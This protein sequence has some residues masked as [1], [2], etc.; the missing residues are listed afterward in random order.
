[1]PQSKE[2]VAQALKAAHAAGDTSAATKLARA[3]RDMESQAEM[4][5]EFLEDPSANLVDTPYPAP[6]PK[7]RSKEVSDSTMW[8]AGGYS[9]E[10]QFEAYSKELEAKYGSAEGRIKMTEGGQIVIK[11]AD[12]KWSVAGANLGR[13]DA[14]KAVPLVTEGVGDVVGSL[15]GGAVGALGGPAAPFT[16][17]AGAIAGGALGASGGRYVGGRLVGESKEDAWRESKEAAAWS[18]AGGTAF[19]GFRLLKGLFR[20]F[21]PALK[22]SD[23]QLLRDIRPEYKD[24][25]DQMGAN[26]RMDQLRDWDLKGQGNPAHVALTDKINTALNNPQI[27]RDEARRIAGDYD[28]LNSYLNPDPLTGK[29]GFDYAATAGM[30]MQGAL[31]A[32][33]DNL[34]GKAEGEVKTSLK[35]LEKASQGL[36]GNEDS[37][38]IGETASMRAS[39]LA[40]AKKAE[41]DNLWGT[42]RQAIGQRDPM[43]P[44]SNNMIEVPDN[45]KSLAGDLAIAEQGAITPAAKKG[46]KMIL[47]SVSTGGGTVDLAALDDA[48]YSQGAKVRRLATQNAEGANVARE[49]MLLDRLKQWRDD[50]GMKLPEEANAAY[51]QANR[52]YGEYADEYEK[53]TIGKLLSYNKDGAIVLDDPIKLINVFNSGDKSAIRELGQLAKKDPNLT[54]EMRKLAYG[55]YRSQVMSDGLVDLNKHKQFMSNLSQGGYKEVLEGLFDAKD[56]AKLTKVG[57]MAETVLTNQRALKAAE[58]QWDNTMGGWAGKLMDSDPS[59]FVNAVFKT[60][61]A[62]N[63]ISPASLGHAMSILK[64]T[65]KATGL[66]MVEP[67]RKAVRQRLIDQATAQSPDGALDPRVLKKALANNHDRL[68]AALGGSEYIKKLENVIGH[69]ERMGSQRMLPAPYSPAG[70]GVI[71]DIRQ[72]SMGALS[73]E[74]LVANLAGGYRRRKGQQDLYEALVNPAA[75][76]RMATYYD[77]LAVKMTIA[78]LTG[79]VAED[80]IEY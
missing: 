45:I 75:L 25:A 71:G 21:G 39:E 17:P 13:E 46:F 35:K 40:Q 54:N 36:P 6:N 65:E 61:G 18:A 80:Q 68:V 1:M 78:N 11:N 8:K 33:Y 9:P 27:Q 31:K 57:G 7:Y 16:A 5:P 62:Q 15:G 74:N 59:L 26:P 42:Y 44:I 63:A 2:Q 3:L 38:P 70:R 69:I 22:G 50:A 19:E 53:G 76:D 47:D 29:E 28:A 43:V 10:R 4:E 67:Y 55:M 49:N 20:G 41:V 73:R 72:G 58:T 48:I 24:V 66:P 79:L 52:A 12:G 60:P 64:K 51:A 34:V 32:E 23:I 30:D 56:M 77:R 37:L 14:K